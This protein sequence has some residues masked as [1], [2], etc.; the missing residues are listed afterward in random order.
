MCGAR[1]NYNTPNELAHNRLNVRVDLVMI[2]RFAAQIFTFPAMSGNIDCRRANFSPL[3]LWQ[4]LGPAIHWNAKRLVFARI[5]CENR[6]NGRVR[7]LLVEE[8]ESRFFSSLT[9]GMMNRL[10]VLGENNESKVK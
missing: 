4:L 9:G 2:G 7:L 8:R 10:I 6:S 3:S 5:H 1:Q